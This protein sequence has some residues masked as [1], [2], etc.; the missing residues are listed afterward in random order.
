MFR[1]AAAEGGPA[2]VEDS[3][4]RTTGDRTDRFPDRPPPRRTPAARGAGAAAAPHDGF[5]NALDAEQRADLRAAARPRTYPARTPLCFQGEDSDH[6]I[7][8]ESGWA[9]VT[10]T[11]SE[12]RD[13][14]LAVRGPG[15]LICESAVLGAAAGRR[16]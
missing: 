2:A 8:I 9:K 4:V 5:W 3:R 6:I 16:R 12:G 1:R 15:D 11:T 13:V 14:V 7:V 10:S